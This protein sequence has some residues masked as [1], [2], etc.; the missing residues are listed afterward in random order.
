M[1]EECFNAV[2]IAS[3][4]SEFG[5]DESL[6]NKAGIEAVSPLVQSHPITR[7]FWWFRNDLDGAV[8]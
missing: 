4:G 8:V 2:T 6:P 3:Q 5:Q 1:K 7:Y